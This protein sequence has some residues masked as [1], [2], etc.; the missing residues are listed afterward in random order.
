[1]LDEASL[2]LHEGQRVRAFIVQLKREVIRAGS[3]FEVCLTGSHITEIVGVDTSAPARGPL[4]IH[5][6]LEFCS[7]REGDIFSDEAVGSL[8]VSQLRI[9]GPFVKVADEANLR[10]LCS[11]S[12]E[13]GGIDVDLIEAV[14]GNRHRAL[15]STVSILDVVGAGCEISVALIVGLVAVDAQAFASDIEEV[16]GSNLCER[17]GNGYLGS[18]DISVATGEGDRVDDLHGDAQLTLLLT[19]ER[20]D[21][22]SEVCCADITFSIDSEVVAEVLVGI[23]NFQTEGLAGNGSRGVD[24][25]G[26]ELAAVIATV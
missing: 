3:D 9:T 1:M 2:L 5:S 19:V 4:T 17:H 15:G 13:V 8:V 23:V 26:D 11:R 6:D 21:I 16:A 25:R 18:A 24:G 22:L 20:G 10:D 14:S 7:I 12:R